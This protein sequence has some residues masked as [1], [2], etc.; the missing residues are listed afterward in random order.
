MLIAQRT[1]GGLGLR[2]G[3]PIAVVIKLPRTEAFGLI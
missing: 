2:G 1:L 3:S